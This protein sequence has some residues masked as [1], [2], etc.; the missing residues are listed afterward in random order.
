MS[1]VI[2]RSNGPWRRLGLAAGVAA[3]MG[4]LCLGV[5]SLWGP[6]GPAPDR[7]APAAQGPQNPVDR[8]G[9]A[10]PA[11]IASLGTTLLPPQQHGLV[12]QGPMP[13]PVEGFEVDAQGALR[14]SPAT[15][16]TLE[17]LLVRVSG[18]PVA[19][20]A[21]AH[22]RALPA[23]AQTQAVDLAERYERYDA[24]LR[25]LF[26]TGREAPSMDALMAD[27]QAMHALR[28]QWF[29]EGVALQLFGPED[30]TTTQVQQWMGAAASP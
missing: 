13:D 14:I 9:P 23:A 8:V 21:Q 17:Q 28:R 15:L 26:P 24:S 5:E 22:A 18:Q 30:E 4:S 12:T 27:V 16:R 7:L 19:P 2:K 25:Q 1:I 11:P 6:A 20:V 29:G 3:L 10:R